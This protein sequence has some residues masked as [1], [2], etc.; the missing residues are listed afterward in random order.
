L[1]RLAQRIG[2]VL[3][4]HGGKLAPVV[5]DVIDPLFGVLAYQATRRARTFREAW[6]LVAQAA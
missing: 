5:F 6:G 1:Q 2:R 3:R 4:P